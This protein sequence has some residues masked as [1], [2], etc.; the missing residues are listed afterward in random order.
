VIEFILRLNAAEHDL[1]ADVGEDDVKA[2]RIA[3]YRANVQP[4]S[5]SPTPATPPEAVTARATGSRLDLRLAVVLVRT[6][7]D[8]VIVGFG[9][10][11]VVMAGRADRN[12]LL[13][14]PI[15][16][17]A[18]G[19]GSIPGFSSRKGGT[20]PRRTPRVRPPTRPVARP[21]GTKTSVVHWRRHRG[22]RR[23]HAPTR[24]ERVWA[25]PEHVLRIANQ[26]RTLGEPSARRAPLARPTLQTSA[27]TPITPAQRHDRA[28]GTTTAVLEAAVSNRRRNPGWASC[29]ARLSAC[30]GSTPSR[31]ANLTD[32]VLGCR[33]GGRAGRRG[34]PNQRS[35]SVRLAHTSSAGARNAWYEGPTLTQNTRPEPR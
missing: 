21:D 1:N 13:A 27:A 16:R 20:R 23:D 9:H 7:T 31:G 25:M 33:G 18:S 26:A 17:P 29:R 4:C 28:F 24:N 19:Y 8:V 35:G 30:R 11:E 12:M 5:T 14:D 15:P 2:G 34:G 3:V 6:H 10:R 32:P 22:R